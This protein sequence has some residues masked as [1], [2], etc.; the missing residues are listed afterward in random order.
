[1]TFVPNDLFLFLFTT[2]QTE[3][4]LTDN[5]FSRFFDGTYRKFDVIKV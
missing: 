1:M 2:L 3:K 5:F 4:N